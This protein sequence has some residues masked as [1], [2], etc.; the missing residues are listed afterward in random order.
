M[1]LFVFWAC[2]CSVVGLGREGMRTHRLAP[3]NTGDLWGKG[4]LEEETPALLEGLWSEAGRVESGQ[5]EK[6]IR[7]V[8]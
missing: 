2:L 8:L 3:G 1:C 4:A 6:A 7:D 5:R